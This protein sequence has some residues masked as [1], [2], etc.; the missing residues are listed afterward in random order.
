MRICSGAG[1]LRA[2]HDDRRFCDECK[3]TTTTDEIR[4]HT[5]G[6]DAEL[7]RLNKGARWQR[8]RGQVL[9]RD[10]LCRRCELS[11]TEEIDHVVPA[12]VAVVQAQLSGLFPG[13]KYAGYYLKSNLQGLCRVC[14]RAKTAEEKAH[15]GE[16]PDVVAA[17]QA[18]PKKV[19]SF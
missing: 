13:D 14:H 7:D 19:W 6:Y 17:E 9:R 2:I 3:P 15:V 12:R 4:T 8:V 10:P 16:W 5:H 1:C 11:M 18:T